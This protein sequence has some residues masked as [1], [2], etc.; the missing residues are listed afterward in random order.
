MKHLIL[1]VLLV[2]LITGCQ[3]YP[4][5]DR[6]S[7][8][9]IFQ[10]LTIDTTHIF[11]N[12][13]TEIDGV[14]LDRIEIFDASDPTQILIHVMVNS[15]EESFREDYM[16]MIDSSHIYSTKTMTKTLH[17][18][19]ISN[20]T[21][22][23]IVINRYTELIDLSQFTNNIITRQA[24]SLN[25]KAFHKV[26]NRMI[27]RGETIRDSSI[28]AHA[29]SMIE[30]VYEDNRLL[31]VHYRNEYPFDSTKQESNYISGVHYY[32]SQQLEIEFPALNQFILEE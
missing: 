28:P 25:D 11:V 31:E 5:T 26:G 8:E 30:F 27:F 19:D 13:I 15:E 4:S 18:I 1:T 12:Q 16:I 7:L 10:N 22:L 29:K 23:Q 9:E 21:E 32:F 14:N 17:E 20:K 24:V 3:R 6:E 2:F